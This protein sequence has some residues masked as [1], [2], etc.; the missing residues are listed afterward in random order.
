MLLAGPVMYLVACS[1]PNAPAEQGSIAFRFDPSSGGA[2]FARTG[3][4]ADVFDSVAVCVFRSGAA[5][6]EEVRQG[7]AI[8]V[9]PI[10]MT[11]SC[12]AEVNKRVSVELFASGV[13]LYHGVNE[14][15]DVIAAKRNDV[16]VD[17][18]PFFV[19]S[20]SV[21]PGIVY[22]GAS[23]DLAWPSTVGA[24]TY[25]VQASASAD[26]A[27]IDWQQSLVDTVT[28]AALPP[29]AH[30]FR[31]APETPYATGTFAG[32]ELSYVIGGSG[33]V[34]ITGFSAV[35]VIPGDIVS[36]YGENLDFPGVQAAVGA[37]L[38]EIVSAA[39]GELVVRMPRAARTGYVTV[40]NALGADQSSDPLIAHR[41]AFVSATGLLAGSFGEVLWSSG[42]D[43]E[44]SGLAYIPLPE[45]DTRDMS[46]FD[47]IV[48]AS[49]T[50]T[51]VSNWGGGVPGRVIAISSSGA[52]VFA[53]GDGGAAFL[54][55]TVS[56]FASA[57]VRTTTQTSC[58]ASM[59]GAAVFTTP[60]GVTGGGLPQWVDMCQKPER[61]VALDIGSLSKPAGVSLYASSGILNDRWLLADVVITDASRS[62]RYLHWGFVAD[63]R[64]L[65]SAGQDCLRNATNL[66]YK[67]RQP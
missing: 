51:D 36:I 8:G 42:D 65:T 66:L 47:V 9:D 67:E 63:P 49:D 4:V 43:I 44:W 19:G 17:A 45:L 64:E 34:I 33:S 28:S 22:D 38:M 59:P 7:A 53:M 48:V 16:L 52:N 35:G 5:L 18:F 39:W 57:P 60:H 62:R 50:G 27:T 26:F 1:S 32:P 61:C 12:I 25:R 54:R 56:A 40:G 37:E 24:R 46:V 11:I 23:F 15:V 14:D 21:T 55:L 30:Y 29:G 13:M 20:L 10:E 3:G 2:L 41:I 6:T 31:V 58:Y